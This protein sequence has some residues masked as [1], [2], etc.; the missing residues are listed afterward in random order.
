M[1]RLALALVAAALVAGC[2]PFC[3]NTEFLSASA[4]LGSGAGAIDGAAILSIADCTPIC[5]PSPMAGYTLAYC[6]L[7]PATSIACTYQFTAPCHK[8]D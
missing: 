2:Q 8:T 4:D 6:A 7:A 3:P 5:P 1:P